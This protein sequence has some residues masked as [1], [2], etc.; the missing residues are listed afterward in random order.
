ML[1]KFKK[2][3][4]LKDNIQQKLDIEETQKA[5]KYMAK[6]NLEAETPTKAFCNQVNKAKKESKT[7]MLTAGT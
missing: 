2:I 1:S 7:S 6:R 4:T 5:R 3:K